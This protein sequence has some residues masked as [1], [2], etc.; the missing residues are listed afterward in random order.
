M[1]GPVFFSEPGSYHWC[2]GEARRHRILVAID[3][4]VL[5]GALGA[6]LDLIALDEVVQFHASTEA[7]R[8]GPFDA[9]VISS[10]YS[11]EVWAEL[12]ITLPDIRSMAGTSPDHRGHLT[13]TRLSGDVEIRDQR[14]IL[15]LLDEHLPRGVSRRER[16]LTTRR[17]LAS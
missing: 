5:E 11:A 15:E 6:I 14:Q 7:D 1:S 12:M 17:D 10:A 2:V 3:P 13:T 8:A 9:A 16:L 4:L